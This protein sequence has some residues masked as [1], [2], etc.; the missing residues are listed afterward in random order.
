[1]GWFS[2]AVAACGVVAVL[3]PTVLRAAPPA[4]QR[5][6]VAI[7]TTA[8]GVTFSLG[9]FAGVAEG[10]GTETAFYYPYGKKFKLSELTW[11]IKDVAMAGARGSVGLGKR[12]RLNLEVS[13]ALNGGSG[14][15]VDR[16]WNYTD[17]VSAFMTPD[18]SNWSDESR[19]PDT[20][21]DK[22]I[23]VDQSLSAQAVQW[24]SL[25]VHGLVGFKSETL[26]WSARGGTF[27]YST[28]DYGS[29]DF[30]GSFAPGREV[31]NYEQRF[32]I[33]YLGVAAGWVRPAFQV[34]A[35]VRFSPA[36]FAQDIDNHVLRGVRFEGQFAMGTYVGVGLNA[37]W[38]VAKHWSA[39]LGVEYQ[40]IPQ[41]T[42]N[43]TITGAEGSG[44]LGD[45]GGIALNTLSYTVGVG[46]RF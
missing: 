17:G 2:R 10:T 7:K 5:D 30:S 6:P 40:T 19:H 13:S 3:A 45:A 26:K 11:D 20:T 38:M 37:T 22:R 16:D 15:M 18:G 43:V 25:Q 23:I 34:L 36:V 32:S 4:G 28:E 41:I 46:Y 31:I 21:L 35:N 44:Y 9:A 33:P 12:F 24:G 42:G 27:L 29:R 1:M 39:V 8:G 14:Q